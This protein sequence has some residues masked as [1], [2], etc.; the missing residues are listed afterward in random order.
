MNKKVLW[1][2]AFL[3][4]GAISCWATASSFHLMMPNMPY[5]AVIA[6]TIVFFVF[7]S[8]AFKMILDAVHNDGS[9]DNPKAKLWGG[10]GLLLLTWV[11]ISLPTNAHTF[12]YKLQIGNVVSADL[13]T[14][15]TYS[16]Q[17]A[18]RAITDS[19]YKVIE[20]QCEDEFG[21]FSNEVK[22]N[23]GKS[24]I[25][26]QANKYIINI[27][28]LLGPQYA[29]PIIQN[30]NKSKD[31][32][33]TYVINCVHDQM[34]AQ[35]ARKESAEYKVNEQA[36]IQAK[37]DLRDLNILQ[38]SIKNL[39]HT[40]EISS[41]GAEPVIK[42]AEGVLTIAYNNIKMN[43]KYVTFN[44]DEDKKLYTAQNPEPRTTRFLNPYV[45]F[46]DFFRGLIPFHFIFWLIISI[47][48]DVLGFI[49]F[50][51]AFKKEYDF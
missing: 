48:L 7:A 15:A 49:S 8:Y 44:N 39:I 43:D 10:I 3:I 28:N 25:G 31:D 33:N 18:T 19:A 22:G 50:D 21:K 29:I 45:V 36:S 11:V 6:M 38:D 20:K 16:Q 30:T 42:Q 32:F 5:V 1:F 47:L 41:T 23:N 17:L 40:K 51:L 13:K 26:D 34:V 37:R 9:V 14:T 46:A 12:F 27:N 4:V 2:I 24:G 35:L